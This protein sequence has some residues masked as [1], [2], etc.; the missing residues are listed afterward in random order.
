MDKR[1]IEAAM[2]GGAIGSV[3]GPEGTVAGAELGLMFQGGYEVYEA[4]GLKET[5]DSFGEEI[6]EVFDW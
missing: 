2:I 3:G 1:L 6:A 4:T 5:V